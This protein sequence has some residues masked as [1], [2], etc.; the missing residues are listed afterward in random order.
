MKSET[1]FYKK[2]QCQ[3]LPDSGGIIADWVSSGLGYGKKWNEY[4]ITFGFAYGG[5]LIGGLIYHNYR[6]KTDVWWTIY[7][8]DKKW[9]NRRILDFIFTYAFKVMQCRRIS[10][11]VSKSKKPSLNLVQ[12]LGFKKEGLL[13]AYREN[14]EDC[15]ILG[16]L[17]QECKWIRNKGDINE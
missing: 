16:M 14:G 7:T 2:M 5:K 12:K 4:N 6:E 17:K 11:L 9:C 8:T 15:Y 13:R 1:E 3:I 10:I